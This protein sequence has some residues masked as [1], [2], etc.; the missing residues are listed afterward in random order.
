MGGRNSDLVVRI[1][2]VAPR[3]TS[4]HCSIHR[5]AIVAMNMPVRLMSV[6][7]EAVEIVNFIKARRLNGT[8]IAVPSNDMGSQYVSLVGCRE[9]RYSH[10]C[11]NCG[12]SSGLSSKTIPFSCHPLLEDMIRLADIFLWLSEFN[13]G[14]QVVR[15]A[16]FNTHDRIDAMA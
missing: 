10:A 9:E 6:L 12:A 11:L 3:P 7:R 1:E 13:L 16:I 5:E 15:G 4:V 14:L 8:V 2:E